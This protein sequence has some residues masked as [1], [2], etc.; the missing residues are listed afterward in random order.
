VADAG[1]SMIVVLALMTLDCAECLRSSAS[2]GGSG[3]D[4]QSG[5]LP[6]PAQSAAPVR[7]GT[8]W[9]RQDDVEGSRL[10]HQYEVRPCWTVQL[11]ESEKVHHVVTR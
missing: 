7:Q 3:C 11:S 2:H 10:G 1:W 5:V 9:E 4:P 8:A 6:H